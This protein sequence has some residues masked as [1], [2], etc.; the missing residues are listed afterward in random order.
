MGVIRQRSP[1]GSTVSRG[2][3][4]IATAR[5]ALVGGSTAKDVLG[6]VAGQPKL[7]VE[8]IAKAQGELHNGI[9]GVGNAAAREDAAA[10]DE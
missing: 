9:G 1:A 3:S 8:V 6:V 7:E 5:E 4:A 10:A 2:G